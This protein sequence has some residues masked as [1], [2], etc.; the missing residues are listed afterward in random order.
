M[1]GII[2]NTSAYIDL[3]DFLR[4]HI[5]SKEDKNTEKTNTRIG[6]QKDKQIERA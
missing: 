4:Q 3:N 1:N 5:V 2:P 6:K